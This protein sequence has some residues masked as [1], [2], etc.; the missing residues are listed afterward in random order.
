M[1]IVSAAS[2][3]TYAWYTFLVVPVA[4]I[5]MLI[6]VAV[7]RPYG[8][9]FENI[10]CSLNF[11]ILAL[12]ILILNL[13]KVAS[14]TFVVLFYLVAAAVS[15]SISVG[16]LVYSKIGLA[17]KLRPK[18][19]YGDRKESE[20]ELGGASRLELNSE[21]S[22]V[23]QPKKPKKQDKYNTLDSSSDGLSDASRRPFA[24]DE[25]EI[26]SSSSRISQ[27]PMQPN[28]FDSRVKLKK[29]EQIMI[30]MNK[31]DKN[32]LELFAS[33][34]KDETDNKH[35]GSYEG[36]DS[37]ENRTEVEGVEITHPILLASEHVR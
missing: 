31:L 32:T 23:V 24:N 33:V 20:I 12:S 29:K 26:S 19:D 2:R 36:I 6:L 11:A 21:L 3:N 34:K 16:N 35:R 18:V 30:E 22:L 4:P 25:F 28:A 10:R 13:T 7:K 5:A 37:E 15:L 1:G 27:T 17:Y 8:V 9:L 14:E